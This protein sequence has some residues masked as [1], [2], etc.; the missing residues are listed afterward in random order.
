M[1]KGVK[2]IAVSVEH[3]RGW[4]RRV[5]EGIADYLHG[6]PEWCIS[7]F[8]DGLPDGVTLSRFDGFLWCVADERSANALKATGKPVV[9]LFD[10]EACKGMACV[11]SD[12]EACGMLAALKELKGVPADELIESRYAKFRAMGN[13]FA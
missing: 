2:R 9:S 11:G 8:E 12:H 5:C 10:E 6:R 13:F 7:M 4:G 3:V 1:S